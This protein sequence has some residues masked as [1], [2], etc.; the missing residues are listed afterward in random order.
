MDDTTAPRFEEL[1]ERLDDVNR[2][3]VK[4]RAKLA[5]TVAA[6]E[7]RALIARRQAEDFSQTE[8]AA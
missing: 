3:F 4:V 5:E 6:L 7:N 2:Q 8:W 1:L